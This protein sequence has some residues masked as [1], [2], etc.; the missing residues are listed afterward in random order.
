[1]SQFGLQ[2]SSKILIN[3]VQSICKTGSY[4]SQIS[5]ASHLKNKMDKLNCSEQQSGSWI[6]EF[7]H[8]NQ[9]HNQFNM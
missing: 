4:Y 1:V 3:D 7:I 8:D 2:E 6:S 9:N 5:H